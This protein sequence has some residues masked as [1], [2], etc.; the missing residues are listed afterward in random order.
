VGHNRICGFE[1][2]KAEEVFEAMRKPVKVTM[3]SK[4][5]KIENIEIVSRPNRL[6]SSSFFAAKTI[7][8][9][10]AEQHVR[11]IADLSVLC[12]ALPDEDV[13]AMVAETYRDRE[14]WR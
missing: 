4:A 6:G 8:Q 5:H 9:L 13:D 7:E 1:Q 14:A 10:I 2:E 12:G 11:P 3:D